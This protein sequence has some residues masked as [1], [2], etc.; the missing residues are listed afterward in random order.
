MCQCNLDLILRLM[1]TEHVV[2]GRSTWKG[3][4]TYRTGSGR[5][6]VGEVLNL[7][8]EVAG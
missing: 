7:L 8:E 2:R 3:L 5:T 4:G 6:G 1:A